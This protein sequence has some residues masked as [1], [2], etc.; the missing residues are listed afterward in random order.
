[1]VMEQ[2]DWTTVSGTAAAQRWLRA[3]VATTGSNCVVGAQNDDMAMGARA[4]LISAALELD[5]PELGDIPVTG[6]DGTVDQGQAWVR[7]RD[8]RATVVM[9]PTSAKAVDVIALAFGSGKIPTSDIQIEERVY[10][11]PEIDLIGTADSTKLATR[12]PNVRPRA[13]SMREKTGKEAG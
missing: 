12:V 2:G 6:C 7:N 5:Q 13:L 4:A 11:F 3:R 8:L 9:P 1:M 10:S